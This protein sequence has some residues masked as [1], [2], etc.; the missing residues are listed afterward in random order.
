[1]YNIRNAMQ[2]SLNYSWLSHVCLRIRF[3]FVH[4]SIHVLVTIGFTMYWSIHNVL[5]N[6]QVPRAIQFLFI[7]FPNCKY[8]NSLHKNKKIYIMLEIRF[9]DRY[10]SCKLFN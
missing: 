4:E 1:M 9:E 6:G 5:K 8:N 10:C 2:M 3:V 7:V